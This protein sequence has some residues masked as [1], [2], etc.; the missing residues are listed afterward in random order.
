M[1]QTVAFGLVVVGAV[2]AATCTAIARHLDQR[3]FWT[4]QPLSMWVPDPGQWPFTLR[5]AAVALR[6]C[7]VSGT[8]LLAFDALR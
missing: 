2:G 7:A 4:R 3:G 8:G 5:S 1:V 6:W